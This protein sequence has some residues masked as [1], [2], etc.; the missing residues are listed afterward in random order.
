[1]RNAL[2]IMLATVVVLGVAGCNKPET[3][4]ETQQDV[5]QAAREGAE[6]VNEARAVR[7]EVAREGAAD[8]AAERSDVVEAATDANQDVAKEQITVER[9][10]AKAAYDVSIEKCEAL[11]GN[12]MD[13]CKS[14]AKATLD[15]AE[16]RLDAR[17]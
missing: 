1:M 12:A 14:T 17:S 8:V 5:T 6:E 4:T 11:K 10:A 13:A 7:N 16:A 9:E 3:A 2:M 15:T